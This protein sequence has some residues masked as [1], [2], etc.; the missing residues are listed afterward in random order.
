M[1][2][3]VPCLAAVPRPCFFAA[4]TREPFGKGG[5]EPVRLFR[6][7]RRWR[8]VRERRGS[9]QGLQGEDQMPAKK[10]TRPVGC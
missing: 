5:V 7:Q 9:G 6:I 10:P 8:R 1:T 4:V 2:S 3:R